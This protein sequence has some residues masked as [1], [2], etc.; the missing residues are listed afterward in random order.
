MVGECCVTFFIYLMEIADEIFDVGA[1][2]GVG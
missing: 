1:G 2:A